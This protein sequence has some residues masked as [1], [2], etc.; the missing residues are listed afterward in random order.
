MIALD[1]SSLIAYLSGNSGSDVE[2]VEGALQQ[3]VAVLPPPVLSEI[4]SDP[5]L[6]PDVAKAIRGIPMLS[7]TAGY[8]EKVGLLRAKILAKGLRARL[9]DT[10]IAQSCLDHDVALIT[11]DADFKHFARLGGLKLIG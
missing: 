10:L 1:T 9:A 7:L 8:W 3:K 4:L 5:E 6:L 2:E 11:R